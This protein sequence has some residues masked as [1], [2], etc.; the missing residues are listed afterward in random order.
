MYVKV[1]AK[2]KGR[3][4]TSVDFFE[5]RGHDVEVLSLPVGD[6]VFDDKVVFEYKTINDFINSIKKGNVFNQAINQYECFPFHYVIIEG[7]D[8]KLKRALDKE[9]RRAKNNKKCFSK[10][11]W[12]GAI[13][14]LCTFTTL[15]FDDTEN[16]CFKRMENIA[17]MCLESKYLV[18][19]YN[20]KTT[21]SS[22]FKYLCY[23]VDD[24]GEK[25]AELITDTLCLEGL[26]DLLNLTYDD[27][28]GIKGIG[29][30]TALS[31]MSCLEDDK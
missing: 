28:V 27:L 8:K 23:C 24:V 25:R 21:G 18:R 5:E 6:Y 3:V 20:N 31:I 9:Y 11:N 22:A 17:E 19:K 30:K 29:D 4:K 15:V 10:K 1:D 7:S 26:S 2:E 16:K 13:D 14:K 12:N